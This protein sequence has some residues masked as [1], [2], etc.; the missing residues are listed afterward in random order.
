MAGRQL[1][2]NSLPSGSFMPI[3]KRVCPSS[4]SGPGD[5]GAHVGQTRCLGIHSLLAK[6]VRRLPVTAGV[7]VQMQP[8]LDHLGL[9]HP[10]E[11]DARPLTVRVADAVGS[12]D[13]VLVRNAELAVV[14]VPRGVTGRAGAS[15]QPRAAAQNRASRSGSA[16]SMTSW[17]RAPTVVL[18]SRLVLLSLTGRS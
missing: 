7:K 4:D 9:G 3:A 5:A 12:V 6:L 15:S 17:K 2:S 11:P 16:Q 13:Q 10:V 14:V 8:V 18:S 1:M